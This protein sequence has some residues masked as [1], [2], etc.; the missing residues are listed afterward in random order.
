MHIAKQRLNTGSAEFQ[1]NY[2]SLSFKDIETTMKKYTLLTDDSVQLNNV[3]LYRI[4]ALTTFTNGATGEIIHKGYK[5]GYVQYEANLSQEGSSWVHAN[6]RV[7]GKARVL[8]DAMVMGNAQVHGRAFVSGTAV[9]EGAEV[10]GSAR[11]TGTAH[12][13]GRQIV[14][15]VQCMSGDAK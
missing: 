1:I 8:G 4:Q 14:E 3:T 11:I 13:A 7:F 2:D 15:G 5:G 10:R 6:A 9:V 12:V